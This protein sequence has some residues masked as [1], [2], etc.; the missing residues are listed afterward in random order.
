MNNRSLKIVFFGIDHFSNIVLKSLINAGHQIE[1]VVCHEYDEEAFALLKKTCAE[2]N[3]PINKY[4]KVNSEEVVTAVKKANPDLCVIGHFERII[5][6][7]LLSI[8]RMGF[9]NLHPSLLPNYRGL[10][11]QH[12][13][14]INGEK[15]TGITVHYVDEGTDTGDIIIQRKFDLPKDLYVAELHDIW[16]DHYKTI[17]VDAI[18][19]IIDHKPTIS[20]QGLTG[21]YY[22]KMK[23]QPYPLSKN[24]PVHKAYNWVRAMSLPY[25]GVSC[26]NLL[27][28]KAHILAD[29]ETVDDEPV[30]SFMDG[31]LVVDWYD[32]L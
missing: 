15:E 3:I 22:E 13:P 11:P 26:D 2:Y 20:Q 21:S 9:I 4:S 10:A 12:W 29:G 31:S 14:I 5:R 19:N 24:W 16:K 32:E 8:P 27:I 25:N 28:F 18:N 17:M 1:L 30:I 23:D 6:K 7:E